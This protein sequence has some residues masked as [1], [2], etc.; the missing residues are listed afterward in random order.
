MLNKK[1]FL[2]ISCFS[3]FVVVFG[4]VGVARGVN[5]GSN[6]NMQSA[7]KVLNLPTPTNPFD[8]ATKSYVD[9]AL[10]GANLWAF[11]TSYS[12]LQPVAP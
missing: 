9:S 8:A 7:Y 6:L 3:I 12:N 4:L 10:G 5:M 1:Q 2:M 11:S